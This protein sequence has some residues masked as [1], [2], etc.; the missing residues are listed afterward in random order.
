MSDDELA[1]SHRYPSHAMAA[2]YG[3]AAAGMALTYGPLAAFA[4]APAMVYVLGGLGT[5][6]AAFG[7]RTAV[8][9]MTRVEVS[10]EAI[11]VQRPAGVVLAWRDLEALSL[12]YYSTRRDRERGWM[13]LKLK[14]PR[15]SV[16]LDS[17]IEGFDEITRRAAATARA[18]RLELNEATRDNLA[19]L[20]IVPDEP[21]A[22]A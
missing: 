19:A 6:F 22:R 4:V 3:R 10:A 20:A 12:S 21:P 15:G 13:Q 17:S 8:R 18:K 2:D 16:K 14:G 5:L 11:R 7:V 9:H 1:S